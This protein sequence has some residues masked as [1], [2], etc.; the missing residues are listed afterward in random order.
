MRKKILSPFAYFAALLCKEIS[1]T[2]PILVFWK[3]KERSWRSAFL[4]MIPFV[5]TL[6]IVLIIR[7]NVLGNAVHRPEFSLRSFEQALLLI[8]AYLRFLIFPPFALYLEPLLSNLPVLWNLFSALIFA[9]GLIFLKNRKIASWSAMWLFTLIPVLGLIRIETTLDERFL[10]LPSVSF[11]LLAGA[12]FKQYLEYRSKNNTVQN[13]QVFVVGVIVALIYAPLLFVREAYWKSDLSL[14]SSAVATDPT[15]STVHFRLGVA[16]LQAGLITE[17]ENEFNQALTL[18]QNNNSVAAA[19][20]THLAI[21]K[22]LLKQGHVEELYLKSLSLDSNYF[23][24]HFNLGLYYQQ[25]G[26]DTEAIQQFEAALKSNPN[27][28]A[29]HRHLGELYTKK[30]LTQDAEQ[31]YRMAKELEGLK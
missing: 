10:Y 9:A 16:Y 14:W 31:H 18:P 19:T 26:R 28:A 12:W 8:P 3:E 15:S 30:G 29:S 6:A 17:A 13:N 5:F 23:T 27:S 1:V 21:T 4:W 25:N 22:Q 24:A 2:T 11:C 20:Y 7:K